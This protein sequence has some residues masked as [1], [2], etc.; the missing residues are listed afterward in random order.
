M[1]D[2]RKIK[3]GY[4]WKAQEK[5]ESLIR[6]ENKL[7]ELTI[8]ITD[9]CNMNCPKCNKTNF[10]F[11]DMDTDKVLDIISEAYLLGL[12][13]IH[14]TGG[15]ATLHSD[16][17]K[18]IQECRRYD[19]RIDMSTNGKFTYQKAV[20][21]YKAGLDSINISWDFIDQSPECIDFINDFDWKVFINHMV[22]PSNYMELVQFLVHIKENY[23]YIIDIQLMPPRGT[24]DKFTVGQL[25]T[26]NQEI[27]SGCYD[28]AKDRF[29]M[30]E[31]KVL[32][33]L[34]DCGTYNGIYHQPITWK[35]HRS[36]SEL[37]VGTKGYSTCTYLYRD[38]LI[39][40]DLEKSVKAA[41]E[42]CKEF[43]KNSPPCD[44]CDK[45]CSPEV[46]YFNY[47]VENKI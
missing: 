9:R 16:F 20:E 1:L 13:H 35:C 26:Y 42:I 36:K 12:E 24:A 3:N 29:P 15:E 4:W 6:G 11:E 2:I 37:R 39:L 41:W 46:A 40:C 5:Y 23:P 31:N 27:A 43:G 47:F 33:I 21:M 18:M 8:Q 28:I 45:S 10:T 7:K 38:G 25:F 34:N 17:P 19:L 32:D 30:V 22:M 14:F 44:M